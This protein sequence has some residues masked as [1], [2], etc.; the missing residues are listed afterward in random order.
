MAAPVQQRQKSPVVWI[1]ASVSIALLLVAG[2]TAAVFVRARSGPSTGPGNSFVV[3][4]NVGTPSGT[5]L[6]QTPQVLKDAALAKLG[7]EARVTEVL[8]YNEYAFVD[9]ETA[10]GP[11]RFE[12]RNGVF[13]QA[14]GWTPSPR[15]PSEKPGEAIIFLSKVDFSKVPA[16]VSDARQRTGTGPSEHVHI[17][18]ARHLPFVADPTWSVYLGQSNAEF[19]MDGKLVGGRTAQGVDLEKQI[20]NYFADP[21]PVRAKL[22]SRFG[23][24]VQIIELVLYDSYS[25]AEVRDPAQPDNVDRYTIRPAGISPGDPMRSQRGGWDRNAFRLDSLNFG[26]FP[27]LAEDAKGRLKGKVSHVIV[28][29]DK[30]R[31]Y[32]S[33]ERNSGYVSYH[34]DG[35]L[36]RV[37]D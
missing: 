30:V 8:L 35:R 16:M 20:V 3:P 26:I 19:D 5:P 37:V 15:S 22:M 32:V 27:R 34:K 9:A 4:G 2:L 12:F 23:N 14:D 11:A 10:T 29:R 25:I 1:V 31:V 33:D 28:E 36:D 6:W 7:A 18:L 17:R 24:D 21:N 13:K